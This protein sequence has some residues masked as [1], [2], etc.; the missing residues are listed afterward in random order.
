[1]VNVQVMQTTKLYY[2][3]LIVEEIIEDTNSNWYARKEPKILIK[4]KGKVKISK[5]LYA[6][7]KYKGTYKTGNYIYSNATYEEYHNDIGSSI[8]RKELQNPTKT[9]LEKLKKSYNEQYENAVLMYNSNVHR[10]KNDSRYSEDYKK[11]LIESE[12]KTLNEIKQLRNTIEEIEQKL[13]NKQYAK[14]V[15]IQTKKRKM[16]EKEFDLLMAKFVNYK[17]STVKR[18]LKDFMNQYNLNESDINELKE[19]YRQKITSLFAVI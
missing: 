18:Y 8:L 19:N 16:I 11:E 13:Y 2:A 7:V 15:R 9:G 4:N 1:M 5:D 10:I 12:T 14:Q 3:D 6:M 17:E